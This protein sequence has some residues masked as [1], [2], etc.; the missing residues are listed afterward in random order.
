MQA[1]FTTQSGGA[2]GTTVN[3]ISVNV[4]SDGSVNT[5]SPAEYEK[6]GKDLG[7]FVEAKFKE[8]EMK[9]ARP[10]G[11]AWQQRKNGR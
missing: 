11:F 3:N 9:S 8:M 6:F 4:H 2:S 7:K 10:G 5:D 1:V